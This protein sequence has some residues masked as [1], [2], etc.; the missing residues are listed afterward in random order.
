M[1]RTPYFQELRMAVG[2]NN[3]EGCFHLLFSQQYTEI[4]GLINVPC[5]QRD[6]LVRKIERM[7]K[8]VE[9]GEGFCVFHDSGDVGLEFMK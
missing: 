5:Q 3:L 8:L 6:D 1:S 9:E 7:E 4:E 2:S